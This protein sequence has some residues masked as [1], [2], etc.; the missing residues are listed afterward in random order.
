MPIAA[1]PQSA[2]NVP[3]STVPDASEEWYASGTT[4]VKRGHD[5]ERAAIQLRKALALQDKGK[6]HAALGCALASRAASLGDAIDRLAAFTSEQAKYKQWLTAWEIAQK[7]HSNPLFGKSRPQPP[8]LLTKDDKHPFILTIHEAK[9]QFEALSKTAQD[10]WNVALASARTP[11]DRAEMS[12]V[13]GWGL[14]L[15]RVVGK[16]IDISDLPGEE[17]I[18]KAFTMATE[19]APKVARYW[20]SL[21]DGKLSLQW[22]I[23]KIK[24]KPEVIAAYKHSLGLRSDN[25]SLWYRLYIMTKMDAP[26]QAK[27]ALRQASAADP[28]NA[29]P[30]Y[31]LAGLLLYDTPYEAFHTALLSMVR[32]H[33]EYDPDSI[34]KQIIS[35]PNREQNHLAA[36]EAVSLIERGNRAGRFS[37][38][39]YMPALPNMLAMAWGFKDHTGLSDN[40]DIVAW[41]SVRLPAAGYAMVAAH[42]G[43]R[44]EAVRAARAILGMGLKMMGNL[45]AQDLPLNS[46]AVTMLS[47]GISN[48]GGGHRALIDVYKTVGDTESMERATAE[49]NSF[50]NKVKEFWKADKAARQ[51]SYNSS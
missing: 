1:A 14:F 24:N 35:A 5:F 22:N 44:E 27:E 28:D 31:R 45:A 3:G 41:Q 6:Y 43:N 26:E 37:G 50:L 17:E 13:R 34:T 18:V 20:Q 49:Y 48:A 2:K 9:D 36:Q 16:D 15:L 10:E 7:E 38:P 29:F 8:V 4:L 12:Y 47:L 40:A 30:A 25:V 23:E 32:K 21:G 39:E 46:D 51:S 42:E 11:A 19:A 33:T